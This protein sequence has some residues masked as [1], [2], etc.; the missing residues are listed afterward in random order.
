[1]HEEVKSVL[2]VCMLEPGWNTYTEQK[3][4]PGGTQAIT[5]KWPPITGIEASVFFYILDF[6]KN[7]CQNGPK[8]SLSGKMDNA[9]FR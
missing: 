2:R 4:K 3:A 6:Q 8:W 5:S 9:D 1:M 7:E